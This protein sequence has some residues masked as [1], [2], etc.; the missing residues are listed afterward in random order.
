M[1]WSSPGRNS[2]TCFFH[3]GLG[4]V[5][6]WRDF[7]EKLL[8]KTSCSALVFSRLG[9]G[10]SD[11]F[12]FPRPLNFLHKEVL[13]ELPKILSEDNIGQYLLIGHS[14]GASITLIYGREYSGKSMLGTISEAPH[15]FC[16]PITILSIKKIK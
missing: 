4:C 12:D 10:K 9:Y 13:V 16:E 7:P 8:R 15:V 1:V 2:D 3:E 5:S 11:L 14:D 6:M